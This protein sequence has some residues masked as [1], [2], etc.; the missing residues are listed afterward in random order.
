[1]SGSAAFAAGAPAPIT[2]R[3]SDPALRWT[4][5]ALT[6]S[7]LLAGAS[8][9]V[10]TSD[11]ATSWQWLR[12]GDVQGQLVLWQ[13]RL[14]RTLGAWCAGALLALAGTIAQGL[15]R[16]PLADPYLLGSASGAG[17]G[18][19]LA[20]IAG[21]GTFAGLAWLGQLGMTG[22]AFVG[23]LAATALTLVLARGAVQTSRLLLAGVIVAFVLSAVSSLLLLTAPDAWRAMQA[24]LLGNTGLLGWPNT[25]VLAGV[26]LAC[27]LP[28]LWLARG[29]DA[30][31]LGEDTARS[32]G[33]SLAAL[34][35][36]FL[37]LLSLA[38]GAAVAQVGVV[39]FVGLIAPHLVR[40]TAALNHRRL[41]WTAALC[42][43]ALLQAAD[44]LS[45]A[46]IRPAELPV[47]VLTACLGGGYLLVL[48]W[49][50][51]RP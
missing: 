19:T 10:G 6:V 21:P 13:I 42:G 8:L 32:M 1:M 43:G 47:G 17:L 34:R 41:L 18:V 7:L 49:W 14:P 28:S 27:L 12:S 50:R 2:S 39:S 24:F 35:L 20:L 30:L 11:W 25:A 51:E 16:N 48:M 29:L 3:W 36:A 9:L 5:G 33:L 44:L 22:A 26:L 46:L 37:A 38:T 23:A 45:R 40:Q 4:I 31:T 15:F